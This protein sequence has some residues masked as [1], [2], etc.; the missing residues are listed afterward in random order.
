MAGDDGNSMAGLWKSIE[1][2]LE[3][4]LVEQNEPHANPPKVSEGPPRSSAGTT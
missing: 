3:E 4:S 1:M 2:L